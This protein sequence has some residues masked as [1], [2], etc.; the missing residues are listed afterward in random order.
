MLV[1][2]TGIKELPLFPS[3]LS[4]LQVQRQSL[5]D[6]RKQVRPQVLEGWIVGF[7]PTVGGLGWELLNSTVG[8][9]S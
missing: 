7:N 2:K 4:Q 3:H 9:L 6:K 5:M 1:G 8:E